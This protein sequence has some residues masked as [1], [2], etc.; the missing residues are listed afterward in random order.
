[1]KQMHTLAHS[2][3]VA[4]TLY[5][6]RNKKKLKSVASLV[7]DRILG[8]ETPIDSLAEAIEQVEEE[9]NAKER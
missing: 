8:K 6:M 7:K 4:A 5:E 9:L 1:M 3:A 2:T